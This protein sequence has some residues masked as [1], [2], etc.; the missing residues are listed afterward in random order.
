MARHLA[1]DR[2]GH[3]RFAYGT[4][5]PDLRPGSVFSIDHP[6][7]A[8]SGRPLLATDLR[9]EGSPDKEWSI[10]GRAVLAEGPYRPPRVTPKPRA[11]GVQTAT[12]VGPAGK[13]IHADEF[14][15][16]RVRFHWDRSAAQ[17][18]ATS[19][20]LRVSQPWAGAGFGWTAL[21][22]VGQEVIVAFFEEDVDQPVILAGSYNGT[23]PAP[24]PLP[25][26]KTTTA[27]QSRSTPAGDGYNELLLDDVSGRELFYLQAE[28]DLSQL[29]RRN[30]TST[31]VRNVSK[32]VK[33][34]E[35]Q[36][37]GKQ[38]IKIVRQDRKKL[39]NGDQTVRVEGSRLTL[40]RKRLDVLVK[41]S[42]HTEVGGDS[43]VTVH[44]AERVSVGGTESRL[45][46][47]SHERTLK[48]HALE[49]KGDIHLLAGDAGVLEGFQSLT[50]KTPGAFVFIDAS[51]IVIKGP[52]VLI[53]S[54]GVA[55]AG[56]GA[57]PAAPEP[58]REVRA[59]EPP[60][61]HG[62]PNPDGDV[63]PLPEGEDT[64][65]PPQNVVE[66]T[67]IEIVLLSADGSPVAG[68][69]YKITTPD[70][71]KREGNLDAAGR[72]RED[73]IVPGECQ[74]TFPDLGP[75]DWE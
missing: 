73:G 66:L 43:D 36:T 25:G 52:L 58:P 11:R 38:R 4:N 74:V 13:E 61:P 34:D 64:P 5:V 12:V 9:I 3:E 35:T 1:S 72:A 7:S 19:G 48:R 29:V 44:G 42:S 37:T 53:N 28:Q 31:T 23:H 27:W 67:W 45:A 32:L 54:G 14:G 51:G 63:A 56:K 20:W 40:L 60:M 46:G 33:G 26:R 50:I 59:F 30:E 2:T 16:V 18:D 10:T 62:A 8:I 15:R 24:A 57:H 68:A 69:R 6:H 49:V 55:G 75:G 39:V 71:K 21:P 70:G 47:E 17:D 65:P 41:G 22:R